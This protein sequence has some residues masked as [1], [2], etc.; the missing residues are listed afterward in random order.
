VLGLSRRIGV[1]LFSALGLSGLGGPI[2]LVVMS[3]RGPAVVACLAPIRQHQL[4]GL[5]PAAR[6]VAREVRLA[7]R[8][9]FATTMLR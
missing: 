5:G 8:S 6:C 1:M 7:S 4:S 9:L 2:G 3:G